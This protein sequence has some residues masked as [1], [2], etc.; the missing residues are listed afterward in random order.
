MLAK[1]LDFLRYPSTWQG[2]IA[3]LA[4]LGVSLS[5]EQTEAIIA[6]AVGVVGTIMLFFSDT[7]VKPKE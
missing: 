3:L 5:P 6:S 2:L 7:D 1:I 4:V